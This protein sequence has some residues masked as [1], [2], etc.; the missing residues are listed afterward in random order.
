MSSLVILL[1]LEW[2]ITRHHTVIFVRLVQWSE[3]W[4]LKFNPDKC[5]VMHIG[6]VLATSYTETR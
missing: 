2:L 3:K 1:N 5:K 4:L 6:H